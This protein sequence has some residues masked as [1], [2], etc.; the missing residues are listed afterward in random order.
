MSVNAY[1]DTTGRAVVLAIT[2][3]KRL[4]TCASTLARVSTHQPEVNS[5]AHAR[6]DITANGAP[7]STRARDS[8]A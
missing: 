5:S 1:L 8:R 7:A 3:A 2:R 4:P 6:Q